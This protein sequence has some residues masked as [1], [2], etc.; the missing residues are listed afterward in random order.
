MLPFKGRNQVTSPY[1]N[2]TLDGEPDF[3]RGIDIVG[4]DSQHIRAVDGGTV[5]IAAKQIGVSAS[6]GNLVV[7]RDIS[8]N[9]HFYAHLSVIS[10][11]V[12]S[13]V[14]AGDVIGIMGATGNVTGPHLHYEVR[15]SG[16]VNMQPAGFIPP[17]KNAKGIYT[18]DTVAE[19]VPAKQPEAASGT[20]YVVKKGDTLSGIAAKYGTTYQKLA[21]ING[22]SNP[23]IIHVG[24]QIKLPSAAQTNTT[25]AEYYPACKYSGG[26]I[27]DALESI[28]ID[29][30]YA[31]RVKIAAANGITG[32][33]GTFDQNVKMLNLLKSGKL[34]KT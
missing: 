19:T 22:I 30:T 29:G 25:A 26:S 8:G 2:R 9:R 3:H 20:V 17:I 15:N 7:I 24:Q 32:Y 16:N 14:L 34:K 12:G 31:F 6:Y 21:Q 1:G 13:K 4:L 23:N 10:A 5:T 28:G 33:R 27:A 18:A 11:A